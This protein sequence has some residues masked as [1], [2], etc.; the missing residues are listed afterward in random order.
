MSLKV[1]QLQL[2]AY[3]WWKGKV[4]ADN[5]DGEGAAE[6]ISERGAE[7][8]EAL[9]EGADELL[10]TSAVDE[11]KSVVF[12]Y[13]WALVDRQGHELT[14]CPDYWH[15]TIASKSIVREPIYYCEWL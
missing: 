13:K 4:R 9:E 10:R 15:G 3:F 14:Q 8:A 11:G 1:K 6:E 2:R 12:F 5:E 7:T